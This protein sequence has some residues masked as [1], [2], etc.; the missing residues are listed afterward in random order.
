MPVEAWDPDTGLRVFRRKDVAFEL[1]GC[2]PPDWPS[3]RGNDP[4][5]DGPTDR[6]PRRPAASDGSGA[7]AAS[8]DETD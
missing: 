1:G 4:P 7:M 8:L 5:G 6:E 3:E 2:P